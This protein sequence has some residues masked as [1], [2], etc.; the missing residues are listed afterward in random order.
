MRRVKTVKEK[1]HQV[2]N[3]NG[4]LTDTEE[5]TTQTLVNF[6]SSV[7]V[8]GNGNTDTDEESGMPGNI[9]KL[10]IDEHTVTNKLY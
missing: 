7:F 10:V 9:V 8:Q 4:Q 6:F 2:M 1:V 5:E 3:E